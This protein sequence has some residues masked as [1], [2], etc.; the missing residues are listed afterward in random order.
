MEPSSYAEIIN[1]WA[2]DR[3]GKGFVFAEANNESISINVNNTIRVYELNTKE[4]ELE[5]RVNYGRSEI[6]I[7]TEDTSILMKLVD[8]IFDD[9]C[10]PMLMTLYKTK[11]IDKLPK[12]IKYTPLKI[13]FNNVTI[14]S[15]KQAFYES[16]DNVINGET[17][18]EVKI[19][20]VED[21]LRIDFNVDC[22]RRGIHRHNSVII[23]DRGDIRVELCEA[24]EG[25]GV[26]T[27]LQ[28][29]LL[30]LLM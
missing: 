7:Y 21:K 3:F 8:K 15:F 22:G 20:I 2:K 6:K 18:E 4:G 27:L 30:N 17:A 12:S 16:T 29:K 10:I 11:V 9:Y 23:N 26:E 14:E 25:G 1:I 24:I 13:N 19:N 28:T 5:L